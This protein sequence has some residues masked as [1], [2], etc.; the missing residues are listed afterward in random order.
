MRADRRG[1]VDVGKDG[2]EPK[3]LAPQGEEAA[4]I[5]GGKTRP[6]S[7]RPG[8]RRPGMKKV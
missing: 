1:E 5:K 6:G 3:D 4:A 2:K 7:K 8:V